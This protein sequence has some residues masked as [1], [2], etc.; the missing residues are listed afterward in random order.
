[1]LLFLLRYH[2]IWIYREIFGFEITN[3]DF[4]F[5]NHCESLSRLVRVFLHI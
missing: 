1:M 3:L 5:W 4:A 2:H